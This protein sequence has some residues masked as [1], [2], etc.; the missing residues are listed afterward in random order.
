MKMDLLIRVF[1]ERL[2]FALALDQ[3]EIV[4]ARALAQERQELARRLFMGGRRHLLPVTTGWC[5]WSPCCSAVLVIATPLRRPAVGVL[6]KGALRLWL[7]LYAYLSWT[8]S[9]RDTKWA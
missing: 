1:L 8:M 4:F 3:H 9:E 7:W 2:A 6:S 5:L